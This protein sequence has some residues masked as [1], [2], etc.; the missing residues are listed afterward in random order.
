MN[1]RS[2]LLAA[3][4]AGFAP[5]GAKDGDRATGRATYVLVHGAWHGGWCWARVRDRLE[6]DGARVFTPTLTGLGERAHLLSPEVGLE[7][8]VRDV[9]GVLDAEELTDVVLCGHSYGGMIATAVADRAKERLRH[10]VYLDAALPDDGESMLTEDPRATPDSLARAE[11]GLRGLAPDGVA[12]APLPP[13][14]FGVPA[15]SPEAAWLARRLTPH[16]L[17]TWFEPVRLARG[18][19][20]GLPRTY[21]HCVEPVLAMA[22]FPA[23]AERVRHDPSWRYVELRTGHDAM[24]TAP[25]QVAELLRTAA[26]FGAGPVPG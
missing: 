10:V 1:R 3:G 9:L 16:P 14:I 20:A 7:T 12:M 11:R 2:L 8:H 13:E 23:H 26:G 5:A 18:G 22:A 25:D 17:R 21:V 24:V 15:G 6:R 4:V 19:S